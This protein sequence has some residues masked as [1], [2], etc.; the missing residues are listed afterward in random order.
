MKKPGTTQRTFPQRCS[1]LELGFSSAL[2]LV[3]NLSRVSLSQCNVHMHKSLLGESTKQY[4]LLCPQWPVL[5][6]VLQ[7]IMS[8]TALGSVERQIT[9]T[10]F[11]G[12]WIGQDFGYPALVLN[13]SWTIFGCERISLCRFP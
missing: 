6:E 11:S 7:I 1:S 8:P 5:V 10:F 4:L 13:Q 9:Q 12:L 3:K 2:T